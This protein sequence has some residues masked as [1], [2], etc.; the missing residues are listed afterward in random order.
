MLDHDLNKLKRFDLMNIVRV[1]LVKKTNDNGLCWST[2]KSE[3]MRNYIEIQLWKSTVFN[4]EI[5]I[6]FSKKKKK[7]KKKFFPPSAN[8]IMNLIIWKEEWLNFFYRPKSKCLM[9]TKSKSIKIPTSESI[10]QTRSSTVEFS[11][12]LRSFCLPV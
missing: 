7:K 9:M 12:A 11:S 2:M 3:L 1:F 10:V 8:I 4:N 6:W 5:C